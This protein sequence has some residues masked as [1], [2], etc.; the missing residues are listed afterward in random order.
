MRTLFLAA[1]C[2]VLLTTEARADPTGSVDFG[3]SLSAFSAASGSYGPWVVE[4]LNVRMPPGGDLGFELVNRNSSDPFN[5]NRQTYEGIDDFHT[6]SK[7]LTTYALV[8]FG[9]GPPF[10]SA[11][12]YLEGD[13]TVRKGLQLT[14]GA[15]DSG[16]VGLGATRYARVGATL[17]KG[18]GYVAV[19]Y[20]P[21]WSQLIGYTQGYTLS[22]AFG[23]PGKTTE[24]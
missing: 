14:L 18:D 17:Y 11:R 21:G 7:L 12:A 5:P 20:T 9:S 23:H 8:S 19:V 2:A 4:D 1:V 3:T 15:G 13:L 24:T 10:A 22:V 16:T 6:W